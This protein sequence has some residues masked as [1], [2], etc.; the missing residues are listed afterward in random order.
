MTPEMALDQLTIASL[1]MRR[2]DRTI[3]ELARTDPIAAAALVKIIE[4]GEPGSVQGR[5]IGSAGYAFGSP[6]RI[7]AL[8]DEFH[9]YRFD[10][11]PR[12]TDELMKFSFNEV[13][14]GEY[15]LYAYKGQPPN[16]RGRRRVDTSV[17]GLAEDDRWTTS[18]DGYLRV[19][20]EAG[21]PVDGVEVT[22][23]KVAA[24]EELQLVNVLPP[25]I[26]R[27]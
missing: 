8:Q 20:V 16:T 23:S 3:H 14:P 22:R 11:R 12:T 13:V 19:R 6:V 4:A 10:V 27:S 1:L 15:E 25:R 7:Y 26:G 24:Y 9:G 21:E 2:L 18:E 5:I 17:T